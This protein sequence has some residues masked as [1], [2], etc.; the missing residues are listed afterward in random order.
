MKSWIFVKESPN[1]TRFSSP[2]SVPKFSSS[3]FPVILIV[4]SSVN[5]PLEAEKSKLKSGLISS[6]AGLNSTNGRIFAMR[7]D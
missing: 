1:K 3:N 4:E 2:A 6:Q 5:F 7:K